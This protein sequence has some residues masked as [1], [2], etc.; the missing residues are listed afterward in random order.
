[1]EIGRQI[2]MFV[3]TIFCGAMLVKNLFKKKVNESLTWFAIA[4]VFWF[5]FSGF[6]NSN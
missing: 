1:M 6:F 5:V 2:V 3:F 4:T